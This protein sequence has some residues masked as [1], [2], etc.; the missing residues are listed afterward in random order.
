MILISNF[1]LPFVWFQQLQYKWKK[2]QNKQLFYAQISNGSFS[3]IHSPAHDHNIFKQLNLFFSS[4]TREKY[5]DKIE[6]LGK[7]KYNKFLTSLTTS[8]D[9]KT[10]ATFAILNLTAQLPQAVPAHLGVWF[11]IPPTGYCTIEKYNELAYI[12]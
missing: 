6:H 7:I 3:S 5:I 9:C 4:P 2:I 11:K 8:R 1:D 12:S 10:I